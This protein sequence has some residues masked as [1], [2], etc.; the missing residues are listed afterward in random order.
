M[1][2]VAA[3]AVAV[4]TEGGYLLVLSIMLPVTAI[5]LIV[6]LGGRSL[7]RIVPV[8]LLAGLGVSIAVFWKVTATGA[9]LVY[10]VGGWQP[11]L[12]IALRA[13]GIAAAMMAVTAIII[14]CTAGAQADRLLEPAACDLE[15]PQR[16][17]H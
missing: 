15:R 2:A 4:A 13:D 9:P 3:E 7:A 10:V 6:A 14:C 5:I 16:A 1:T 12:G 17:L 8:I 11:P